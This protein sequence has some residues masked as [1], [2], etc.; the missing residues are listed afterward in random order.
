MTRW[1]RILLVFSFFMVLIYFA[2]GVALLFSDSLPLPVGT[3]GRTLFGIVLIL[4]GIFRI[5]S[6]YTVSKTEKDEE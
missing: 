2:M 5:Y 4:Y 3:T 1:K 6:I